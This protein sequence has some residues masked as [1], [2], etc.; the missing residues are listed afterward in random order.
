V[1]VDSAGNLYIADFG[2]ARIR[3]VSANGTITTV[4]G[5]G[6]QGYSG[7]GGPATRAQLKGVVGVATDNAGNLYISDHY[8]F[9]IR[10]VSPDG[11]I[12]T[13]AGNGT[14]GNSGDGGPATGAQVDPFGLAV[15]GAGNLYIAD[16]DHS[17][18]RK[19]SAG[20]IIT[21]VAGSSAGLS[22]PA[23]IALDRGGSLYIGELGQPRIKKVSANGIVVTIAGNGLQGY[24]GDGGPATSAALHDPNGLAVDAAGN[25]YVTS[26]QVLRLLEPDGPPPAITA[27]TSA[28][29]NLTG[30]IA[31]GEIVVLYHSGIGPAQ[32]TQFSLNQGGMAGAQLDRAQVTFNGTPAPLLYTWTTQL[33]AVVPYSVTGASAQVRLTFRGQTSAPFNLQVASSS[34]GIFTADST[35]RGQAAVL[36][37]NG[38]PNSAQNPAK[39]GSAITLFATGEGQTSP[40]GV[41]GKP[42]SQPLP[43]PVLPVTVSIGG[44]PAEVVSKGG[45]PGMVAGVMEIKA[46]IP[47]GAT[48]GNAVPVAVQVG[49]VSSQSGVTVAV[50]DN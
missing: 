48:P 31:P 13:F 39:I 6:T 7:D 26:Y 11:I 36:N 22:H 4:A 47:S 50:S 16:N 27:V 25:V 37:E 45:A 5:T 30:S 35:G 20:G 19:V 3:K 33:A 9:R 10:K 24:S 14:P 28:A 42:G 1:A 40:P 44:Q 46:R 49:N 12:T 15:D 29:S 38:T 41:D 18:I 8:D 17:V 43:T 2:D 21:T 23:A 34:P 32:L